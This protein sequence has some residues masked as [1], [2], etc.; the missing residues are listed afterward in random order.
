V[1]KNLIVCLDGTGNEFGDKNSNV[2]KLCQV[3][4]RNPV[5][6]IVYYHPGIGT[7]PE[8]YEPTRWGRLK[9]WFNKKLDQAI[10]HG[11]LKNMMAAYLFLMNNYEPNDRI[12]IFGFSRGAYT[13]RVLCAMLYKFGLLDRGNDNLVRYATTLLVKRTLKNEELTKGFS[14]TFGRECKVH[15]LGVWD[16]VSSVSWLAD[17]PYVQNTK[18]NP[19]ICCIRHAVSIDECR[20]YF[21]TNLFDHSPPN[22]DLKEVWFP[23]IHGDIGGGYLESESA[24]SKNSFAWMLR[25]AKVA[26]I[27][28]DEDDETRILGGGEGYVQP[29]EDGPIHDEMHALSNLLGLAEYLPKYTWNSKTKKRTLKFPCGKSRTIPDGAKIHES[30]FRRKNIPDLKYNP[31]NLPNHYEVES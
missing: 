26:G 3:L 24:L 30:V 5:S 13:A 9:H 27:I 4:N 10:G 20:A 19:A 12:Y 21:R 16:T 17:P 11:V 18:K 6:Q 31:E 1:P 2:V 8:F 15:F 25:E 22:Q 14:Q 28:V 23:G 29:S 7:Q